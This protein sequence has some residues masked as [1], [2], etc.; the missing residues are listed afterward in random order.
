MSTHQLD[1][2]MNITPGA[3][4]AILAKNPNAVAWHSSLPYSWADPCP[5]ELTLNT[6]VAPWDDPNMRKAVS[7]IIDRNQIIS[8]AYEGTST[9][10]KTMFVQY[11]GMEPSI[12]AIVNAG[13]GVDASAHVDQAD[14]LLTAAGWAK[15]G[16]GIYA[17]DGNELSLDILTDNSTAEYTRT[18]DVLVEQFQAAGINATSEPVTGATITAARQSGNYDAMYNWEQCGSVNEPW[19]SLDTMNV[20]W[21]QPVG[22]TANFNFMRWNTDGAKAYSQ[23]VDQIG[24]LPLGDPS[25]PGLVAQAY[26][27]VYDETAV[28]PLVQAAKLVPFD[29]TYWK[30]WPTSDNN[31]LQPTTWWENTEVILVHLQKAGSS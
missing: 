17:K 1:S 14:A 11:G 26:K 6:A 30:G 23:I 15:D 4:Q 7:L 12:D 19:K 22:T 18:T 20:K 3:F 21:Y 8:V 10:S 25:I 5:R 2:V 29:T 13:Y 9:A 28:I 24:V 31:Y 27:Y 16:N